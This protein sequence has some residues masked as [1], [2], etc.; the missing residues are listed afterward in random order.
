MWLDPE[1]TSPYK[2]YQFW[3]NVDDRDVGRYLRYFTLL[4]ARGDRGAGRGDGGATGAA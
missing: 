3:L 1:L 2:F 4:G